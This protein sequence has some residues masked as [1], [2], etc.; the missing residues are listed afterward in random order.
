MGMKTIANALVR[1]CAAGAFAAAFA[2][3]GCSTTVATH[4]A[5]TSASGTT[6]SAEFGMG[7][8]SVEQRSIG[9]SQDTTDVRVEHAADVAPDGTIDRFWRVSLD[10]PK[11]TT[12]GLEPA[13]KPQQRLELCTGTPAA[14]GICRRAMIVA[15][16][17]KES[18]LSGTFPSLVEPANLGASLRLVQ[19]QSTGVAV[20]GNNV[21]TYQVQTTTADGSTM[22]PTIGHR[23]T[24]AF[25]VW[26]LTEA[27]GTNVTP[28]AMANSLRTGT[29]YFCNVSAAGPRCRA[30]QNVSSIAGVL[31]V[32]VLRRGDAFRHV[33]WAETYSG[34]ITA[35]VSNI[36]RCEADDQ[37]ANATCTVAEVH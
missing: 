37:E 26:A 22:R 19:S 36:V 23:A 27:V 33:L 24:P 18:E 35:Q 17:G 14:P 28:I 21:V 10:P 25:G 30:A 11:G 34:P 3:V 16:D 13:A 32:H 15:A 5:L 12:V 6:Q 2:S 9:A 4:H 31:A 20:V 8:T 1:A 7:K 29:L